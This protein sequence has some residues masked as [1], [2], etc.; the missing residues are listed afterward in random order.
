MIDEMTRV[1]GR[2]LFTSPAIH[3]MPERIKALRE[4]AAAAGTNPVIREVHSKALLGG[5]G[6]NVRR[7]L[8]DAPDLHA[9]D[10]HVILLAM[11]E[12]MMN[13]D[14]LAYWGWRLMIDEVPNVLCSG[15]FRIRVTCEAMAALFYDLDEVVEGWWR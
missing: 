8:A 7:Q 15:V 3:L 9:D 1:P 6:G 13:A 2:Y 10:V 4:R 5:I 14:L 11:H 12:G